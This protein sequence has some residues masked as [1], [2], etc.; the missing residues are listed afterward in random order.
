[1]KRKEKTKRKAKPE[2]AANYAERMA[3]VIH[4]LDIVG[5]DVNAPD[6]PPGRV[7][8]DHEGTP[9]CYVAGSPQPDT[10]ARELTW[11]LLDRG[12]D[13]TPAFQAAEVNH[14]PK[15]AQY[16]DEWTAQRGDGSKQGIGRNCCVQ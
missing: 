9:I 15:F 7:L 1:M 16:V 3:M 5:L 14:N 4:L 12:A 6:Q 8:P 10:D 13:P 11:L 2:R